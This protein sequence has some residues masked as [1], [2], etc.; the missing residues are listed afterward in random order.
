[1]STHFL[2]PFGDVIVDDGEVCAHLADGLLDRRPV[3]RVLHKR[4]W[5]REGYRDRKVTD[6]LPCDTRLELVH[7]AF[8]CVGSH[9][10]L[11]CSISSPIEDVDR[12]RQPTLRRSHRC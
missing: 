5:V 7:R 1:M 6:Q 2:V 9:G 10:A 12:V 11:G 3:W 8:I 4:Y